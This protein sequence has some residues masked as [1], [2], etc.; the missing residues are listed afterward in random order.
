MLNYV[1]ILYTIYFLISINSL[2][3]MQNQ[4]KKNRKDVKIIIINALDGFGYASVFRNNS[5]LLILQDGFLPTVWS[6]YNGTLDDIL[7]F[8]K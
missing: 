8:D 3:E 4:L 1:F 6:L 7:I 2:N 5:K